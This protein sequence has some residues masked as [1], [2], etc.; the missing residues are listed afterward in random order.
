M[1][2]L[3]DAEKLEAALHDLMERRGVKCWMSTVFDATDFETLI[4][5]APTVEIEEHKAKRKPSN[6]VDRFY[7]WANEFRN[8]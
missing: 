5:E 1:P 3:I 6:R 4:D 7:N 8:G 2:R